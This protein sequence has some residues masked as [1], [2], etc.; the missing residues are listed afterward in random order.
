MKA[1]INTSP[2]IF[3][4]KLDMLNCLEIYDNIYT[5]NIVIEEIEQGSQKGYQ[6]ALLV[7]KLVEDGLIILK[8]SKVLEGR[9]GLHPGEFSVIELARDMNIEII[10]VDDGRV[11]KTAKYFGLNVISTPYLLVKNLKVGEISKEVYKDKMAGLLNFGY[12][13]S[14][15]LYMKL[16]Q[17]ADD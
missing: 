6:E 11:I 1:V 5:T 3:L 14:P 4:S 8:E 7:M 12:Y 15:K 13:I 9:Y 10:I 17:I 2:L 16:L